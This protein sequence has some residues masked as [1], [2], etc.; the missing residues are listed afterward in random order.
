MVV[1]GA[2]SVTTNFLVMGFDMPYNMLKQKYVDD[3]QRMSIVIPKHSHWATGEKDCTACEILKDAMSF[4]MPEEPFS[5]AFAEAIGKAAE[6]IASI[7]T[8][9]ETGIKKSAEVN[10]PDHYGGADNPYEVIKVIDAWKLGFSLGNTVKY[11]VRAG[12]KSADIVTDLKKALWYLQHE[13]EEQEKLENGPN[14]KD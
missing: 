14:G 6:E 7:A 5:T 1:H 3:G 11:I 10:H 12:R 8:D 13:I 2:R 9:M 4:G